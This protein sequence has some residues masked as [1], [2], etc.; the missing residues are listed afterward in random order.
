VKTFDNPSNGAG[1]FFI[2]WDGYNNDGIK[3]AS[4]IYYYL[5]KTGDVVS[6]KKMILTR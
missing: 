1:K 4:G 2:K 6:K 5:L 3:M